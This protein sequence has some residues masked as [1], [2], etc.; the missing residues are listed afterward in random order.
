MGAKFVRRAQ[1]CMMCI[2]SFIC[3]YEKRDEKKERKGKKKK[4]KKR[5]ERR[6]DNDE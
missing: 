2:Y 1:G 5:K 4:K 6:D 3:V